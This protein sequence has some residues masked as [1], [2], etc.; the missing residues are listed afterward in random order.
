MGYKK[1]DEVMELLNDE[2]DGFNK[3]I[4]RLERLT[5]KTDNI[6]IM[7]DTSEIERLLR[8][9]LNSEK[10]NTERLQE[11]LQDIS[12]Q[13]SKTR[14]ISK[15]QIGFQYLIWFISLVIIGY[16][17]FKVSRIDDVREPAFNE[18]EQEVISDL[19]EYFDQY[20]QQYKSY[21]K[22]VKEKDSVPNQK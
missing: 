17:T 18:D 12:S 1:L 2:L 16:L 3:A 22:W 14:L 13:I 4:G 8:E 5:Q 20:P 11:S 10:A 6:K 19:R 15:T 9:H 21:Q 7:P